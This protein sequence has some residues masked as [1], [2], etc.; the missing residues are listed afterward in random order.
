MSEAVLM[1]DEQYQR[2]LMLKDRVRQLNEVIRQGELAEDFQNKH[3]FFPVFQSA[4]ASLR[5]SYNAEAH[6][7]ARDSRA[8]ISNFLGREECVKTIL[9]LVTEFS[10]RADSAETEKESVEQEI[11]ELTEILAS[12]EGDAQDVGGAMG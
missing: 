5:E 1:R 12:P 2:L 11:K 10:T 4:L 8:E 3:G 9:E 7:A 6:K